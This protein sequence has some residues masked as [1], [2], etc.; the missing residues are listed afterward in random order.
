VVLFDERGL[1]VG[2]EQSTKSVPLG[3]TF[4]VSLPTGGLP[5]A[6]TVLAP[7]HHWGM[8][9]LK[10]LPKTLNAANDIDDGEHGLE[11]RG[12]PIAVGQRALASP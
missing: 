10:P 1:V 6:L 2:H 4:A 5:Q 7:Q 9:L 12:T 8:S 3:V 11:Q